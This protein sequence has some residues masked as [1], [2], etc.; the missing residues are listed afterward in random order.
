M[1]NLSEYIHSGKSHR[2]GQ[3]LLFC[4]IK[5]LYFYELKS[6]RIAL[7]PLR[8]I[9]PIMYYL[10]CEHCGHLNEIKS[11]Y[12]VFCAG[13]SK[14]I[15]SNYTSWS[16]KNEGKTLQDFKKLVCLSD[17]QAVLLEKEEKKKKIPLGIKIL[18]GYLA[19]LAIL[20]ALIML[21]DDIIS[22]L[23]KMFHL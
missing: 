17:E 3:H 23:G 20:L 19:A 15:E 22:V 2:K 12:L 7:K 1:E 16:R 10:K 4:L 9:I 13:C 8:S 6:V 14:K 18:V 21:A 11:E 5:I